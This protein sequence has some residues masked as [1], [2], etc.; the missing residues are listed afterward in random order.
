MNG[1][2]FSRASTGPLFVEERSKVISS[3]HLIG[4]CGRLTQASRRWKAITTI[5]SARVIWWPFRTIGSESAGDAAVATN[6]RVNL[7]TR[8]TVV[9]S[10]FFVGPKRGPLDRPSEG[11]PK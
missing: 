6:Q 7:L 5:T 3:Q 4:C 11:N 10:A 1:W 9:L 2:R 8:A